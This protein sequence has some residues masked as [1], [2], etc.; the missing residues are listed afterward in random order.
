MTE[1]GEEEK[2]SI[3]LSYVDSKEKPFQA[4]SGRGEVVEAT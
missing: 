4:K 1:Q 2:L 3:Y